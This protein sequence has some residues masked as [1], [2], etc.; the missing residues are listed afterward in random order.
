MLELHLSALGPQSR[1]MK[2]ALDDLFQPLAILLGANVGGFFLGQVCVK[3]EAGQVLL[4]SDLYAVE[5][6]PST[7]PA[8]K[9]RGRWGVDLHPDYAK[10]AFAFICDPVSATDRVGCLGTVWRLS[11]MFT[12]GL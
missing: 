1:D 4:L 8:S 9:H 3:E 6:D 5:M 2:T 11:H 12:D 7:P 10:M